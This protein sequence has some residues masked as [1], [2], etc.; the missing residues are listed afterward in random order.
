M[1]G[2][3][4]QGNI[5][6]TKTVHKRGGGNRETTRGNLGRAVG[7]LERVGADNI[8]VMTLRPDLLNVGGGAPAERVRG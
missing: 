6:A 5:G 1:S 2:I 4:R 7:V 8:E 3:D